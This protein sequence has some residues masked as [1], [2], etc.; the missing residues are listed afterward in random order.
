MKHTHHEMTS[1]LRMK[2]AAFH[3]RFLVCVAYSAR[4]TMTHPPGWESRPQI[5]LAIDHIV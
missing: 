2:Y 5:L 4:V 3:S 1:R